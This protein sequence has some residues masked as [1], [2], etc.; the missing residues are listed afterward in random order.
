[1]KAT[2]LGK[3]KDKYGDEVHL[4]YSYKGKEY[5]ITDPHNGQSESLAQQHRREQARIDRELSETENHKP[6][7]NDVDKA[8][9]MLLEYWN[10]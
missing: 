10:S 6:Y 5:M 4:F 8:I 9:D 7:V 2:Y 1:M 3:T